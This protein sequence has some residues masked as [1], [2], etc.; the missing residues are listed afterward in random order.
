MKTD[1]EEEFY[2]ATPHRELS[3]KLDKMAIVQATP[4]AKPYDDW[5]EQE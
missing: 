3:T 4:K 1:K 5:R 2:V